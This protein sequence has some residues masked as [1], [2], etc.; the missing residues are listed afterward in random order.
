MTPAEK[1][2]RDAHN[3]E[4]DRLTE[5]FTRV[6]GRPPTPAELVR[7]ERARTGLQLR[8]PAQVRRSAATLVAN[9]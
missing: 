1:M 2:Q 9:L 6:F 3:T 4:G 8:L 7:F 5:R